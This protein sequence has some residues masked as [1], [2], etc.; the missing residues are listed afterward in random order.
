MQAPWLSGRS[1]GVSEETLSISS[2]IRR[3]DKEY[4]C[5]LA[6]RQPRFQR[7]VDAA[8]FEDW[9]HGANIDG[10]HNTVGGIL[11]LAVVGK[12]G[13]FVSY[14]LGRESSPPEPTAFPPLSPFFSSLLL[15][16]SYL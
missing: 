10:F 13:S 11:A 1:K 2:A 3:Q 8:D 6:S 9:P 14:R 12:N 5:S 16:V 7:T 15:A 4:E